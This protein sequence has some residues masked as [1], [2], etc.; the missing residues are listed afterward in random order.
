MCWKV[1]LR[2]WL[3]ALIS[4]T[5]TGCSSDLVVKSDLGEQVVI[6]DSAVSINEWDPSQGLRQASDRFAET[7]KSYEDC[8]S[9]SV[10]MSQQECWNIYGELYGLRQR[11]LANIQL[12]ADSKGKVVQVKFRPVYIDL[13]G[14]KTASGDYET[15]SCFPA[16]LAMGDLKASRLAAESAGLDIGG[17]KKE[18]SVAKEMYSAICAKYVR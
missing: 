12:F 7:K 1:S 3:P 2:F 15:V 9:K 6:K 18:G 10:Y 8:Y 11:N 13:N 17:G 5:A 14:K 16:S 4:L